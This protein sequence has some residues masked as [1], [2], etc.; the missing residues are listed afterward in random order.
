M[1]SLSRAIFVPVIFI[2]I[3]NANAV[4]VSGTYMNDLPIMR[5][6]ANRDVTVVPAGEPRHKVQ[7]VLD[8]IS[9]L[10]RVPDG[11]L[12]TVNTTDEYIGA[13][14]LLRTKSRTRVSF[15]T[16]NDELFLVEYYEKAKQLQSA[17]YLFLKGNVSEAAKIAA[18]LSKKYPQY[19]PSWTMLG[20]LKVASSE[21]EGAIG[22]L[23]KAKAVSADP[24]TYHTT[25]MMY[26]AQGKTV[27][28]RQ[29]IK[30]ALGLDPEL[31][32]LSYEEMQYVKFKQPDVWGAYRAELSYKVSPKI[33]QRT[34][35]FKEYEKASREA[36]TTVPFEGKR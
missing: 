3:G 32:G 11:D 12:F 6:R 5:R 9:T 8:L 7:R 25:A 29:E 2:L 33:I 20:L 26:V 30:A 35:E 27:Q 10:E 4:E 17:S 28:A 19:G 13:V 22:P 14:I 15:P 24:L 1:K 34:F 18:D 16:A 31:K 21:F 36:P 23:E